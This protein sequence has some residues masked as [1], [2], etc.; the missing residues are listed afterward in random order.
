MME[1]IENSTEISTSYTIDIFEI[2]LDEWYEVVVKINWII[3]ILAVIIVGLTVWGIRY[4]FKKKVKRK[5]TL[6]GMSFGIGDFKCNLKCG[7]EVQE[8]IGIK[9]HALYLVLYTLFI[10]VYS[11]AF[12]FFNRKKVN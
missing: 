2:T 4:F 7:N 1:T 9:S 11:S 3:L 6:D 5:I 12:Y 10:A 8:I